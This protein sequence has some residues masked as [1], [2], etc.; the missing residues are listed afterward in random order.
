MRWRHL[1]NANK[2]KLW[3]P[4]KM[5]YSVYVKRQ[6][7]GIRSVRALYEL[8]TYL[9][10][11]GSNHEKAFV[12]QLKLLL[13]SSASSDDFGNLI[14]DIG[15][16]KPRILFSCHTDTVCK[17][18]KFSRQ[19]LDI[20]DYTAIKSADDNQLGSDDGAGIWLLLN[21]IDA[22]IAGRYIFHRAEEIGGQGST[23]IRHYETELL[24]GI[25]TAIAFDRCDTH[26]IITHMLFSRCCSDRFAQALA[27]AI[28][29]GH[30]LDQTGGFTDVENY[31]DA[32]PQCTNISVGYMNEHS[33]SEYLNVAYLEN[34]R[35]QLLKVDWSTLANWR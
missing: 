17:Q 3:K 31:V 13:P 29:M 15:S 25:K 32:I 20:T 21:M 26:S 12:E 24:S 1:A 2:M 33:T 9:R 23:H 4:R 16:A 30:V 10:P 28:G 18:R 11:A 5:A 14:V 34:L 27:D 35:D 8:L 22:Q 6:A 19:M 7:A